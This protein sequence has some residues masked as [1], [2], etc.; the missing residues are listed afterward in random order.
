MEKAKENPKVFQS[1]DTRRLSAT[2]QI[3]IR[4]KDVEG[5]VVETE[6][7]V[8]EEIY[9]KFQVVLMVEDTVIPS[10]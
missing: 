2:E 5:R 4:L 9:A 6:E 8:C 3:I 10:L 1:L 7:E